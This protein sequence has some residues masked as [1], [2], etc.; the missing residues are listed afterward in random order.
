[1]LMTNKGQSVRIKAAE[2][3]LTGRNAQG[4]IL[5]K[6]KDGES[7]QDIARVVNDDEEVEEVDQETNPEAEAKGEENAASEEQEKENDQE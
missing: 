3:R 7:I 1:M 4:V 5:M 6:T 2:A